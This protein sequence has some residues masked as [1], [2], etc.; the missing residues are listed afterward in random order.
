MYIGLLAK[1]N[2]YVR[3]VSRNTELKKRANSQLGGEIS[4][5]SKAISSSP[6]SAVAIG[7][8]LHNILRDE[9]LL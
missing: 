6:G 1:Q 8:C 4:V 7:V 3:N 9:N 5:F 2:F